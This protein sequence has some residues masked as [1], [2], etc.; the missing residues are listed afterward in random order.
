M[1]FNKAKILAN[2]R[3]VCMWSKKILYYGSTDRAKL[4]EFT[5][6]CLSSV[7]SRSGQSP[8]YA[9]DQPQISV[10]FNQMIIGNKNLINLLTNMLVCIVQDSRYSSGVVKC[11]EV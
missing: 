1:N 4:H 11:S 7:S 10:F 8:P 9:I 2:V 5:D 3:T 6:C